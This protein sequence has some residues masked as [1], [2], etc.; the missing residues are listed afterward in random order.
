MLKK[1]PL[2]TDAFRYS[3]ALEQEYRREL[4]KITDAM[5]KEVSVAMVDEW[6]AGKKS[7]A[8]DSAYSDID[9]RL[10]K[11]R[12]KFQRIFDEQGEE[13]AKR[14]VMRQ[15]RYSR[16]LFNRI[17]GKIMPEDKNAPRMTL[18]GSAIP[19]ET[20][21]VIKA[22]ILENVSLIRSIEDKYF[23]QITGA[24]T[25]SMQ[26]GGSIKQLKEEILKYNGMTKRRADNIALDQTRK[27]Y[28][29]INL[30]NMADAGIKQAQWLHSG[31]G[32][33]VREYHFR[34]WDGV[35][36]KNDGHPNGLDGFIFDISR[37]PVIQEAKGKQQEIRGFPAQ[38]PNC[39]CV[40]KAI[41]PLD[42]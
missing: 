34:K 21:Q 15:F 4:R 9:Q 29:S 3:D 14:M 1:K 20:E 17:M 25:R 22:S 32:Q 30:R 42:V 13:M 40:L 10:G 5:L 28:M 16:A 33:T 41:I 8:L 6:R 23:E 11:L 31:G 18:K 38:L 26:S 37:P 2:T 7:F 12:K 24:I 27:A 19:R 39:R 36:G 35:S